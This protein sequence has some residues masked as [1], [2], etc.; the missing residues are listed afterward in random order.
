MAP[1]E[2][3]ATLNQY[4]SLMTDWVRSC[5]GFVDKFMGDAMLVVFGLFTPSDTRG[6]AAAD[7]IRCALGMQ[8]RLLVLNAQRQVAGWPLRSASA[9]TAA[10]L[11][12]PSAPGPTR[13]HRH[14]R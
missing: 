2:V 13:V 8:E 4:F 6:D 9:S 5:G 14:R 12:A 10:V 1:G 7:A 3:V 11:A